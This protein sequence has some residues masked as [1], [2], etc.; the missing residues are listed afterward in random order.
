MNFFMEVAKLRAARLLWHR[1]MTKLGAKDERSKM[2]RTHCQTSGVSLQEQDPYNNVIRTTVEAMAAVLGGTQSL[3]TNALDEAIALPTDFSARIAR[4]TQLVIQ[5]E[6]GITKVVDPLGGSYYVEALT[7][8]LAEKAWEII[9]RVEAEGGMTKAIAAGWPKAMIEEA[10]AAKQARV[11]RGEDV[12]VGVNKYKPAEAGEIEILEVDN[13]RVREAQ[14]AR[15]NRVKAARDGAA[16]E[17]ALGALREG[18][19]LTSKPG[20]ENNLLALAVDA[21]RA[22][23]TLGEISK[24]MEDGFGRYETVP[25][26]VKGVYGAAYS[27]DDRWS[28]VVDGI[29]AF[30]RR[31]GRK[32]RLLVA[33][34][35]Q[36]GHDRGANV[37]ASAFGDMGFEVVSGPLF[38]TPEETLVLALEKDVDVVGA[39][40]LAAG[41]KTLI[42]E[43]VR[44]LKDNGRPDIRVIAGG[45][46]PAQDYDY[47]REA[48][49][50]GIYGPGSNIVECAAD[51][52]RLLGHNMPPVEEAAE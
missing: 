9:E 36:D 18:A 23:A 2:L 49:V 43:L 20:L 42:P 25:T 28:Q 31:R 7:N 19:R 27:G 24:A 21:A 14:V 5:E 4:N 12:I 50:V 33:K 32:P 40:S 37:V 39:S 38:Q 34:M 26:P 16:C 29:A 13:H 30:E 46:I 22:R 41:H 52:L 35:G 3:H 47:L 51:V 11:D 48:G 44:L 45:V 8:E 10:A 1:V 6:T 17:A 15:I